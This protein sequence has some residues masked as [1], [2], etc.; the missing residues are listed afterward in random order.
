[1]PNLILEYP[2]ISILMFVQSS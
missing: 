1:M 2:Y